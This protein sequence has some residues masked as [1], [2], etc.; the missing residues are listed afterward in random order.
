[1]QQRVVRCRVL[2]SSTKGSL[3]PVARWGKD[4]TETMTMDVE[5]VSPCPL[6][7]A[8][9]LGDGHLARLAAIGAAEGARPELPT[10]A[11]VERGRG[12]AERARYLAALAF[13]REPRVPPVVV[14]TAGSPATKPGVP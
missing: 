2:G 11:A 8:L 4:R 14:R 5:L 10:Q 6:A 13:W 3:S 12:H 1:M 7:V 9:Q